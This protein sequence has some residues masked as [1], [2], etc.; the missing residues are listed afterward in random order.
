MLYLFEP[1]R[2]DLLRWLRRTPDT[3]RLQ[4]QRLLETSLGIRQQVCIFASNERVP[5]RSAALGASFS[6][7][8]AFWRV[9]FRLCRRV[10]LR[11]VVFLGGAPPQQVSLGQL[12]F[13]H[14]H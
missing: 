9:S 3:L 7:G 6:G 13:V 5:A 2:G 10:A 8:V 4:L 14:P 11:V 1:M 12:D